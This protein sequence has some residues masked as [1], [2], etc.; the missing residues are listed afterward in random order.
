L[1]WDVRG[2]IQVLKTCHQTGVSSFKLGGL[3]VTFSEKPDT[4]GEQQ[5]VKGP[6]SPPLEYRPASP[7]DEAYIKELQH[8]ELLISDPLAYENNALGEDSSD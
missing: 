1:E 4:L 7:E 5:E 2:L 6:P 3:E 8:D